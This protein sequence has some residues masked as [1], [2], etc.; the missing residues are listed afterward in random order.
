MES[1]RFTSNCATDSSAPA[2]ARPLTLSLSHKGRGD[3]VESPCVKSHRWRGLSVHENPIEIDIHDDR[4]PARR[5][6]HFGRRAAGAGADGDRGLALQWR[7]LAQHDAAA[8]RAERAGAGG[9][10]PRIRLRRA[11]LSL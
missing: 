7:A 8:G 2:G 3:S 10:E 6:R 9:E 1:A 4:K 11:R 5:S